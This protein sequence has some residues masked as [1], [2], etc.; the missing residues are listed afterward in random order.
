M[1]FYYKR[2][3][4]DMCW[5]LRCSEQTMQCKHSTCGS[6][7][8]QDNQSE[9]TNA[10]P[11]HEGLIISS[12][13]FKIWKIRWELYALTQNWV[14]SFQLGSAM[15]LTNYCWPDSWKEKGKDRKQLPIIPYKGNC[16]LCN[17][18]PAQFHNVLTRQYLT[19][20]QCS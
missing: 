5:W 3:C 20:L 2:A 10:L 15:D 17:C 12:S 8:H 13:K 7:G 18:K 6:V 14:H 16:Q 11:L 19:T 1:H 9:P 4:A